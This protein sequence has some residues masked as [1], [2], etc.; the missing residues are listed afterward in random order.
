MSATTVFQVLPLLAAWA[1]SGAAE[2]SELKLLDQHGVED[3]LAAHRG[4]VAVV[5]VVDARRLRNLKAWEKKLRERYDDLHYVRVADVAEDPPVPYEEVAEKLSRR[6]P[7]EVPV[8]IDVERR[9]SRALELDTRR[10]NLLIFDRRG[11][12][13]ASFRGLRSPEPLAEVY[14]ALDSL[15]EGR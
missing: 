15:V 13:V 11:A 5:M 8:L 3:S 12:L 9:W 2:L 14:Q 6:V 7:A 1:V 4:H 10:P